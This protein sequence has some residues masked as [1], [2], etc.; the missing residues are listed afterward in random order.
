MYVAYIENEIAGYGTLTKKS[1]Y[2]YFAD[3]NI[4]EIMDLNVLPNFRNQGIATKILNFL[5]SDAAE[6]SEY[7]GI[8]V[9]LYKDYGNA[10]SI[11]IKRGYVPNKEGITYDYKNVLPGEN[12][13]VDD[14]LVLWFVKML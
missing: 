3:R 11:Y 13:R 7:V 12:Y 1:L 14:D 9:G 5:E 2:S 8:G 6:I 10:Q 4:P